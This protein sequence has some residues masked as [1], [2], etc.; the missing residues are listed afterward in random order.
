ML[1][2]I[3]FILIK[4]YLSECIKEKLEAVIR[5]EHI[6]KS[7]YFSRCHHTL[8][9]LLLELS[10]LICNRSY[11]VI[12]R[13]K[14]WNACIFLACLNY[15]IDRSNKNKWSTVNTIYITTRN[16][17]SFHFFFVRV[18]LLL[19]IPGINPFTPFLPEHLHPP[20]CP[21]ADR[22]WS[23]HED[24]HTQTFD[25]A[26]NFSLQRTAQ[27]RG[28]P[29]DNIMLNIIEQASSTCIIAVEFK[30]HSAQARGTF[31]LKRIYK[32]NFHNA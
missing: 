1:F 4:N 21:Q 8:Q 25:T 26:C 11:G 7:S 2:C 10:V 20:V 17:N 27:C 14:S 31:L 22:H 5:S 18:E 6:I 32:Y 15:Y 28:P 12:I 16:I 19:L 23:W 9:T 24:S 29:V 13:D 3:T 30:I